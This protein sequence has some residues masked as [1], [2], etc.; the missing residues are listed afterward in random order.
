MR[1]AGQKIKVNG[2]QLNVVIEGEGAPVVLL[3]GFPDSSAVWRNQIKVLAGRGYKIVAPDLRGY[4]DSDAPQGRGQYTLNI[5]AKDVTGLLDHLGIKKAFVVG[6]NWGAAL[7][8]YLAIRHPERIER[9][10][11]I[12]VGH[13]RAYR[14]GIEQKLRGWYAFAF[15]FPVISEQMV[16]A[17]NWYVLRK[18]TG[19]H[20][21]NEIWI[22]DLS[23]EG[24]RTAGLNWYRASGLGVMFGNF[25]NV[26]VP[27]LG[28]WSTGDRFLSE[29]QMKNSVRYVDADWHYE[30]I[31]GSSHWIPLDAP[32]RLNAL[33]LDYFGKSLPRF[34]SQ[35]PAE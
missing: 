2:I 31:E 6:H 13:P 33:L 27:V 3:H 21:E 1:L 23:R 7:G 16:R 30:K 8:W 32:D 10:V 29:D 28:I 25:P 34:C 15:Q 4:G 24:R 9:Y 17:F 20:P 19:N 14:S 26:H 18:M 12:S 22:K 5:I 11:A 35:F